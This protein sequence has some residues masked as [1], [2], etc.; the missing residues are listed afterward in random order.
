MAHTDQAPQCGKGW[1]ARCA[2]A[3]SSRCRCSCGGHNH[4]NPAARRQLQGELFTMAKLTDHKLLSYA[5]CEP[6]QR[7]FLP[8]AQERMRDAIRCT[9]LGRDDGRTDNQGAVVEY[10]T[11]TTCERLQQ[12]F[13]Y[14]SPTGFEFGYGGSGPADLALNILALVIPLKEANRLHQDFKRDFVAR[15]DQE[16]G[17]NISVAA[18]LDWVQSQWAAESLD[19]KV[20]LREQVDAILWEDGKL[21]DE[22]ER[23]THDAQGRERRQLSTEDQQR[24]EAIQ[25]KLK[26][27]DQRRAELEAREQQA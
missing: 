5:P 8:G 7:T 23:I 21:R 16:E 10:I 22:W 14:H 12:R 15:I 13:V 4:G 27:N 1:G 11:T 19:P 2:R 26:D 3:K 17:G 24:V 20:K 9:R 18:V 6:K 25:A